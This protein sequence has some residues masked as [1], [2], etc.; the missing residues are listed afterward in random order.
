MQAY[1]R[2][3]Y[4][5]KSLN[6]IGYHELELDGRLSGAPDR[7]ALALAGDD[8]DAKAIAAGFID[9]LGYDPVDAG[10][11]VVTGAAGG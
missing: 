11:V 8:V 6:H 10:P 4:V 7:R 9:R 5:V 3:S 2:R 1:L